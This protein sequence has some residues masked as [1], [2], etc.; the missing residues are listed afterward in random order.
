MRSM[1]LL[2]IVLAA[3]LMS[4]NSFLI[5]TATCSHHE[6]IISRSTRLHMARSFKPTNDPFGTKVKSKKTSKYSMPGYSKGDLDN[7]KI[8]F[9]L[10]S[11]TEG[12]QP[13]MT[14]ESFFNSK[15][16]RFWP[17]KLSVSLAM[18]YPARCMIQ[19]R[20]RITI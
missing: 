16:L 8:V 19:I 17:G 11:V 7:L 10:Y 20:L 18:H 12:Q 4:T 15:Y 2:V 3:A 13:S 14:L 5:S 6:C 1:Q 9:K